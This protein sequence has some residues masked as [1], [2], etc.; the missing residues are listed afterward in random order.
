MYMYTRI[1]NPTADVILRPFHPTLCLITGIF[2]KYISPLQ[3]P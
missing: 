1:H 3:N 2:F